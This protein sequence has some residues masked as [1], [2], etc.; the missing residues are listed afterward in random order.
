M[1]S[2]FEGQHLEGARAESSRTTN[3]IFF[4]VL[5]YYFALLC[6]S[7]INN[8]CELSSLNY[9]C[10]GFNQNKLQV[11]SLGEKKTTTIKTHT[12]S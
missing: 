11:L 7:C 6:A 3:V 9:V 10:I 1:E 8:Y 2:H 4:F 12:P 5:K